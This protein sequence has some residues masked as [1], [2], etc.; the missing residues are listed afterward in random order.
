M[1]LKPVEML[2]ELPR[3]VIGATARGA[4]RLGGRLTGREVPVTPAAARAAEVPTGPAAARAELDDLISRI[5]EN[6]AL[7]TRSTR[8]KAHAKVTEKVEGFLAG[9]AG[10]TARD[11]GYISRSTGLLARGADKPT[12]EA[13][14]KRMDDLIRRASAESERIEGAPFTSGYMDRVLEGHE[15]D[16]FI[17]R[18]GEKLAGL[19]GLKA[20]ISTVG[21]PAAIVRMPGMKALREGYG[22]RLL[23]ELQ[24]SRLNAKM[25]DFDDAPFNVDS[26]GMM[27]A[28]KKRVPFGDLA[29]N[30]SSYLEKGLI[31]PEQHR[32][33]IDAHGYIDEL[34]RNYQLVSGKRLVVKLEREHYWP[35][36]TAEKDGSVG[37]TG[38]IFGK[39]DSAKRRLMDSVKDGMDEGVEYEANPL[40]MLNLYATGV[41][42]MTRDA[43]FEK[44]LIS[45]G[46]AKRKGAR[47]KGQEREA[48]VTPDW[49]ARRGWGELQFDKE[50]ARQ[51]SGPMGVR[52]GGKGWREGTFLSRAEM[53]A[54]VPKLIITG[55]LDTG[56]FMIQ[57]VSLLAR[58]PTEWARAVQVGLKTIHDPKYFQRFLRDNYIDKVRDA[59]AHGVN[60]DA[61]SE[62]YHAAPVLGRIPVVKTIARRAQAGFQSYLGVGRVAMYD[63]MATVA[64]RNM[65]GINR[66]TGARYTAREVE[67]ELL[68]IGRIADTLLGG[69]STKGLGMSATQR[70][71]ESAFI[72]FAPRYTRSVFGTIGHAMGSGIGPQETRK[73]LGSM[74]FG[75]AEVVAGLI[76][77]QGISQGKSPKEIRA[78]IISA[79]NP[80]SGRKF[81]SIKVGDQYYG[82]GGGY[83]AMLRFIGDTVSLDSWQN[84]GPDLNDKLLR[85]PLTM[86]A[87]SKLPVTGGLLSDVI[88][89]QEFL[90]AEFTLE[91]FTEDPARFAEAL[92]ERTTPFPIQAF[93]EARASGLPTMIGAAATEFVGGRAVPAPLSEQ[94]AEVGLELVQAALPEGVG[95]TYKEIADSEGFTFPTT[96]PL[97]ISPSELAQSPREY[98]QFSRGMRNK[99]EANP[100]FADLSRRAREATKQYNPRL[101]EYQED[102]D[103]EWE[104]TLGENGK[105]AKLFELSQTH[106]PGRPMRLYRKRAKVILRDFYRDRQEAAESAKRRG[107]FRGWDPDGPFKKAEDIY[108]RLLFVD[109][110]E[111]VKALFPPTPDMPY[112]PLED[113]V[114][115]DFNWDEYER[116]VNFL[117]DT[118]GDKFVLDMKES[119][120]ANL[121]EFERERRE[122]SEIIAET[123]YWDVDKTLANQI[124]VG[125]SADLK[126]YR[127]LERKSAPKAKAFLD[128]HDVLRKEVINKVS[129]AR[130]V[131]RLKVEGLDALLLK[132]GY[133]SK[134]VEE[135]L[136]LLERWG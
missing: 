49:Q 133:I 118:Y 66:A 52:R 75:G 40:R 47:I 8:S 134:P 74:V 44:R 61:L 36:F 127:R 123:G 83:R 60:V 128:E 102:Q 117:K 11:L 48:L 6:P 116:R 110:E 32:W 16:N 3:A 91:A 124:G 115:G 119:S 100:R 129:D 131:L 69:T 21:T 104:A 50:A 39:G 95:E 35:R 29:E 96:G 135:T 59:G 15:T 114:T 13:A 55:L 76:G 25:I 112:M 126:E 73:I 38:K 94:K 1:A 9:G 18:A 10:P 105:L 88:D 57:G 51:L 97:A 2:E 121:P 67:Q 109:D 98:W 89:K 4:G 26:E 19:P 70:Q 71:I 130:K 125:V 33:I 20:V 101:A 46:I 81:M 43:I 5:P 79:L 54:A 42:K 45:K 120:R 107:L 34:A 86:Y 99:A 113:E 28:G 17:R 84:M 72:F 27:L 68:Q 78:D 122:A 7:R 111:L 106:D 30:P 31:T 80:S 53:V 108:V 14:N 64:R 58:S 136:S 56:H 22:Y 132:Y 63:S 77:L 37:V 92:M 90:G 41:N 62:F 85:N 12:R 93:I 24:E 65:R 87:R 103:M 23:Q 82:I